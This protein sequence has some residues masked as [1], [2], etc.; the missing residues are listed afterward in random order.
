MGKL[1]SRGFS[2][3]RKRWYL[4][5]FRRYQQLTARGLGAAQGPQWV[6]GNALV[7]GPGGQSPPEAHGISVFR[8]LNFG[9]K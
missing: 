8:G 4:L 1:I 7:G 3:I 2:R 6:Q 9:I 5:K